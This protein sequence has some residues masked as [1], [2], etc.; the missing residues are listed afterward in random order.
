M[1]MAK[2]IVKTILTVPRASE[3]RE[4]IWKGKRNGNIQESMIVK[5]CCEIV[6]VL[7]IFYFAVGSIKE[8]LKKSKIEVRFGLQSDKVVKK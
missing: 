6:V 2:D 4:D 8:I 3:C 5:S 1:S 7:L